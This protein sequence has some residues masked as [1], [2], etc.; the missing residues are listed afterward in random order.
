MVGVPELP[1][2]SH[3][4]NEA[5]ADTKSF[6]GPTLM[7]GGGRTLDVGLGWMVI[8]A[9]WGEA[10]VPIDGGAMQVRELDM[11]ERLLDA[12]MVGYQNARDPN[13]SVW[14]LALHLWAR[15]G[16]WV[17]SRTA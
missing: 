8:C 15:G 16:V 14:D 7:C 5:I 10:E 9:A 12:V 17:A 3:F 4:T 11:T 13:G 6:G 2:P 1:F